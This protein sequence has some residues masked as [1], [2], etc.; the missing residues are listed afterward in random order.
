MKSA[1]YKIIG[2]LFLMVIQGITLWA[3]EADMM[4]EE[5]KPVKNTFESIFLIDNQTVMVPYKGTM[6]FDIQHRF[7]LVENGYEDF[8]GLYAT[9][10]IRLGL[11]YVPINNLMVGFGITKYHLTWDFNAKYAI[12]KQMSSGGSP[13]SLTYFGNAAMDTRDEDDISQVSFKS[14]D[15]WSYFHQLILARKLTDKLSIQLAGSLSHFNAVYPAKDPETGVLE[16]LDNDHF[17][18]AISAR[19]KVSNVTSILVNYDQ[20]LTTHEPLDTESEGTE[21]KPNLSFGVE[22][23]TSAHQFQVFFGNYGS[24][25][26]Q[27][28]NAYNTDWGFGSSTFSQWDPEWRIGFNMTRLWSY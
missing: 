24:I 19:Y 11:G 21:P 12:L 5:S 9:S 28:N 23:T 3:Q 17:A 13:V 2:V 20:P 22:F 25:V 27:I 10:N 1:R 8:W 16:D 4:V 18:I 6:E 7:G 26:P 14:S 15:R